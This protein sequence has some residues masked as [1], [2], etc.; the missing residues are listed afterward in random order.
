MTQDLLRPTKKLHSKPAN[1]FNTQ[2]ERT[3]RPGSTLMSQKVLLPETL[4]THL[5]T[6]LA[7]AVRL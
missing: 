1:L 5:S 6:A 7:R 2:P 3:Q 4:K